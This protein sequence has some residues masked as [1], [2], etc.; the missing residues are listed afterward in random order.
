MRRLL[1]SQKKNIEIPETPEIIVENNKIYYTT[2]DGNAI[3]P[4]SSTAFN[5]TILTNSFDSSSNMFIIEFSG[6]LTEIST[7]AFRGRELLATMFLPDTVT[8]I[9]ER[10]FYYCTNVSEIKTGNGL[11]TLGNSVFSTCS[12]LRKLTLSDKIESIGQYTFYGLSAIEELYCPNT[13]VPTG[14]YGMFSEINENCK[15]Y[16]PSSSV[17]SYKSAKYWS[18][19]ADNIIGM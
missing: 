19:V 17:E 3:T 2:T 6:T 12:S 4:Y 9:G 13:T 18:D 15:I 10:A 16:V 5:A 7:N 1:L 11:K 8:T 14:K